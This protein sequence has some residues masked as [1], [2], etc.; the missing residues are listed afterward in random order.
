MEIRV[1]SR[2]GEKATEVCLEERV[3]RELAVWQAAW[4]K[5]LE[6]RPE[7]LE[8]IEREVHGAFRELA[9][10]VVARLLAGVS[11]RP[12]FEIRAKN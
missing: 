11:K 9:D 2:K 6:A 8:R 12:E 3:G 5:E 7:E 4:A 1:G 10:Q